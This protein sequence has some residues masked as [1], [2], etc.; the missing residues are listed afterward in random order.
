MDGVYGNNFAHTD[1]EECVNWDGIVMRNGNDFIGDCYVKENRKTYDF[2]IADTIHYRRFVNI[3]SCLKLCDHT[4]KNEKGWR[5]LRSNTKVS[6]C[7]GCARI[8]SQSI[9]WN[10]WSRYDD[11][12][13]K[14]AQRVLFRCARGHQ[15]QTSHLKGWCVE[16]QTVTVT[17]YLLSYSFAGQHTLLVCTQL[18]L[19]IAYTPRHK[20][21]S[22]VPGF[23]Q[24]RPSKIK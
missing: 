13:D 16:V 22:S 17:L 7:M 15:R 18:R 5:F 19:V 2:I 24:E 8:E 1:P 21:H 23:T 9:H 11:W 10:S 4:Q 6:S 12:W 3:K 20:F 14:L